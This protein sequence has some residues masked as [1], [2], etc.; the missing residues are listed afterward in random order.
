[1]QEYLIAA[2]LSSAALRV[3]EALKILFNIIDRNWN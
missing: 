2:E 1:M 3:F